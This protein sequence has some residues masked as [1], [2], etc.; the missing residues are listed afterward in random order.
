M[1]PECPSISEPRSISKP[2]SIW[3]VDGYNVLH[4]G[5][6]G[7]RD[8]G[9]WWTEPRRRELLDRV[10]RFHDPLAEIWVVFD[11]PAEVPA[12][13]DS[14]RLC[15][16]APSADAWLVDRVRRAENPSLLTVVTADRQ[17]AGRVSQRGASVL[18]PRDFL[19]HC[20]AEA[21]DAS[22]A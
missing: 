9:Q 6:L 15:V 17:I 2:S 1:P 16:F 4:T 22:G 13:A 21:G 7:G 20:A 10:G 12:K 8:R 3:L 14:K 18:S 11:G 19:S 5:L